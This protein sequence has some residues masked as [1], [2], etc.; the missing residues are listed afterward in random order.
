MHVWLPRQLEPPAIRETFIELVSE[1][2][3]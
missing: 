1:P 3:D 2:S